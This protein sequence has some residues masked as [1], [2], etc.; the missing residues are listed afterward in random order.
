MVDK[1]R[2]TLID[3]CNVYMADREIWKLARFA[4]DG[5]FYAANKFGRI[6][7]SFASHFRL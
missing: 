6:A 1:A 5:L 2:R 7:V 3:D 4:H